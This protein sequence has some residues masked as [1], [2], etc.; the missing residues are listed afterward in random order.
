MKKVFP[1]L[2]MLAILS[3]AAVASAAPPEEKVQTSRGC[4]ACHVKI[5]EEKN[6]SLGNE[7]VN[8]SKKHP[9]ESPSGETLDENTKVGACLECHA[10]AKNGKGNKSPI[11]LRDLVHPAHMFSPTFG[12]KLNGDCFSCH[13]VTASGEFNLLGE[14][15]KTNEK[16]IPEEIPIPGAITIKNPVEKTAAVPLSLFIIVSVILAILS[17]AAIS[18]AASKKK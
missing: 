12:D 18:L 4:P 7:A 8:A 14:K 1:V 15:L 17:L 11:S 13:N 6:Y 5:S 2:C 9:K 10:A 3:F 16:G